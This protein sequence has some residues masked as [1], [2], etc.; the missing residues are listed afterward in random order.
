MRVAVTGASG[1]VGRHVVEHSLMRGEH[2]LVAVSRDPQ[3]CRQIWGDRV[4]V[5]KLDIHQSHDDCFALLGYPDV[6]LHLAWDG[7]PNYRSLTHFEQEL[8]AQYAFLK[9]MIQG[10]LKRLLVTGTC[11]EYGLQNGPLAEDDLTLPGNPYGLAK[12]TLR[13][14]LVELAKS[15]PFILQWVRL[16]YLYGDGQPSHSLFGQ[17]DRA[18]TQGEEIFNLSGGEQLRDYLPVAEVA[19]RLCLVAE[20]DNIHGVLNCCS[21]V[22]IS[23]RT[24]VERRVAELGKTIRLNFGY[25]PYP[26]YEPMAF[27]GRD[28]KTNTLFAKP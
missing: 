9:R 12:D 13:K 15:Q 7:L 28:T 1:F 19:R 22:P 21:G 11:F 6:L 3:N 4:E 25:Y 17:L 10:G 5:V 26:D 24:L 20:Q 8:P 2:T 18:L 16:F 14:F 27:W 23:I